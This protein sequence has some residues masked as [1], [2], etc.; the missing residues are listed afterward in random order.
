MIGAA[1]QHIPYKKPTKTSKWLPEE[2][3][4]IT[5]KKRKAKA[6]GDRDEARRLNA[7][8]QREARKDKEK[9]WNERCDEMDENNKKGHTRDL[10]AQIK[11]IRT[12]F[13]ARKGTIKGRDRKELH[14]QNKMKKRWQEY[15]EQL[16]VNRNEQ[17]QQLEEEEQM[18]M[19]ADLF[20]EELIWA[21]KQLPKRKAP[22][23]DGIPTE[24]LKSLPVA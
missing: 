6:A 18:E 23:G 17:Q 5:E 16:Y 8:F 1:E 12:P 3:I 13:T 19:E 15:M 7:E 20:E 4:N 21:L 22:G 24:L 11:K 14:E 10:F 9:Y 2:T